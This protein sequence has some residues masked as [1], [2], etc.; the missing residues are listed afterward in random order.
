MK[1]WYLCVC[2]CTH[3]DFP[4]GS[5]G[6]ESARNAGDQSLIPASGRSPREGNGYPLQYSCL[7]TAVF[8]PGEF[9]AQW[10]LAGYSLWGY[11][12]SHMSERLT[13]S[14]S[15]MY[16]HTYNRILHS[17]KKEWSNAIYSNME[18]P[19]D[20]YTKWSNSDRESQM[21]YDIN[22]MCNLKYDRNDLIYET[23]IDSNLENRPVVAKTAGRD[24]VGGWG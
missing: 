9:H 21:P 7:P 20:Y 5:D 18:G 3:M 16:I 12:E 22:Y 4:G 8:L 11:R 15:Y 1:M 14:V 23:E 10:S 24:G 13:L 17:H 2:V 6:K 19:R